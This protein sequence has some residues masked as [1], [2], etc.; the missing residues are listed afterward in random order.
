MHLLLDEDSGA[1]SL[2]FALRTAGHDVERVVDVTELGAG[3]SDDAVFDYAVS[4]DRVL[5]TKNGSDFIEIVDQRQAEHPGIVIMHYGEGG[6]DLP[7]AAI[8]NAIGNIDT[9]YET[10]RSLFLSVNQHVW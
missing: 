4:A 9:T 7:T 1:R 5:I 2:A 3:A 6:A 8:V 10:V